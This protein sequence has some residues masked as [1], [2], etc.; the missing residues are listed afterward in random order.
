MKYSK[1]KPAGK[2]IRGSL[3]P[4]RG[5]EIEYL[6]NAIQGFHTRG[7][8]A[9]RDHYF[10]LR[11]V[12]KEDIGELFRRGAQQ[13]NRYT[14]ISDESRGIIQDYL[15]TM[16]NHPHCS[17]F[18]DCVILSYNDV[19]QRPRLNPPSCK[20]TDVKKAL[21]HANKDSLKEYFIYVR[22]ILRYMNEYEIDFNDD[23]LGRYRDVEGAVAFMRHFFMML[24]C[25]RMPR[26][27]SVEL[28][29]AARELDM[30]IAASYVF[31]PDEGRYMLCKQ[32][33]YMCKKLNQEC[34][35]RIVCSPRMD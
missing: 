21:Q 13:C 11:N 4:F 3:E 22:P 29:D 32:R 15:A 8:H 23:A 31:R 30:R 6:S 16:K 24:S 20:T 34:I 19:R 28:Y 1:S 27:M 14:P 25:G 12:L 35:T 9:P 17:T 5:T 2:R 26:T 33:T 7:T 10:K 18:A